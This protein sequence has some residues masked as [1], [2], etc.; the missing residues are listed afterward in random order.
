MASPENSTIKKYDVLVV[1]D[2]P[3]KKA[4]EFSVDRSC[5]LFFGGVVKMS[6]LAV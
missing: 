5:L 2:A 1:F 3:I 4:S 6:L